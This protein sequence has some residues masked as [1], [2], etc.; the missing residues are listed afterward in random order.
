MKVKTLNAEIASLPD[1]QDIPTISK[2][3]ENKLPIEVL[4]FPLSLSQKK[5]SKLY[6][7]TGLL[8]LLPCLYD[9]RLFGHDLSVCPIYVFVTFGVNL[10]AW[11][12]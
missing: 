8:T 1:I 4:H 10:H 2:A 5:F 3:V 7:I 9:K 6:S 11:E 12:Q